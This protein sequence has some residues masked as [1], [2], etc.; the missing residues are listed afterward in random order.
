MCNVNEHQEI[1][2][3]NCYNMPLLTFLTGPKKLKVVWR[4]KN[5]N[6]AFVTRSG[7]WFTCS[8]FGPA[9]HLSD[10][11]ARFRFVTRISYSSVS[12]AFIISWPNS[13]S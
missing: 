8:S 2:F 1:H 11:V 10:P 13:S 5:L 6:R 9:L 7:K 3:C 4:I 12:E